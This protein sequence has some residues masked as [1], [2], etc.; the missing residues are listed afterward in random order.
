M[1]RLIDEIFM[2]LLISILNASNYTKYVSLSNQN[3]F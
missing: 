1:F 2:A 3:Y